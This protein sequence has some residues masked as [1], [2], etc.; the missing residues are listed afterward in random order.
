VIR[1]GSGLIECNDGGTGNADMPKG[2]GFFFFFFPPLVETLKPLRDFDLGLK[3]KVSGQLLMSTVL[4]DELNKSNFTS[5][6]SKKIS[7]EYSWWSSDCIIP[8]KMLGSH[9]RRYNNVAPQQFER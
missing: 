2:S 9:N 3:L 5:F 1:F 7:I 6:G 4:G 8:W